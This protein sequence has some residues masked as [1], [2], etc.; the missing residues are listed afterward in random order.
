MTES[1]VK[2]TIQEDRLPLVIDSGTPKITIT[3]IEN[4]VTVIEENP[5]TITAGSNNSKVVVSSGWGSFGL[6]DL[7][8]NLT[9]KL[10]RI[11]MDPDLESDLNRLESLWVRVGNEL[12]LTYP[13]G[14]AIQEAGREY[15]D[16]SILDAVSNI[17]IST[18][19]KIDVAYSYINQ[20][21]S[22]IDQRIVSMEGDTEARFVINESRILQTESS[23]TSTVSR[24]DTIDGAGGSVELLQSSIDQTASS[25]DLEVSARLQ[26][27]DDLLTAQS[28]ISL[29]SDSIGLMVET[30]NTID[31]QVNTTS[32]V[33]GEDCI[34]FTIL[35]ESTGQN[36]YDI[37]VM[38][39]MLSN[40]WGVTIAEDVD[41]TTYATGFGLLL[42]PSWLSGESYTAGYTVVYSDVVYECKLG[43]V[44]AEENSPVSDAADTYWTELPDGVR[45]E[46]VISADALII[47][48]PT[49]SNVSLLENTETTPT[50]NS[51][52]VGEMAFEDTVELAKLGE[53]I[54]QGG[55]LKTE[56]IQTSS[57]VIGD[58]SGTL[59]YSS[60]SGTKPASDADNTQTAFGGTS[61]TTVR[62]NAASGATFTSANAGS[63]AYLSSVGDSHIT[64]IS[65]GKLSTGTIYANGTTS[66]W[67]LNTGHMY[68]SSSGF[69][70]FGSYGGSNYLWGNTA[71]VRTQA[72]SY[73]MGVTTSRIDFVTPASTIYYAG[74]SF[75]PLTSLSVSLGTG[76]SQWA[77][78]YTYGLLIKFNRVYDVIDDLDTLHSIKTN[79]DGVMDYRSLPDE[80]TSKDRVKNKLLS[81]LGEMVTEDD[82]DEML[83]DPDDVGSHIS[84][85][86]GN[87]VGLIEG[88]LR[89]LD[90]ENS[91]IQY[92][93]LNWLGDLENRLQL[94]ENI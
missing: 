59:D 14:V 70:Y 34:N 6:S 91:A 51:S 46:F 55:Y 48:T 66:Y 78:I 30:V 5:I 36:Q 44:S 75:Y 27:A 41:G 8:T 15:T 74:G 67:N 50:L 84:L 93:L 65:G 61:P 10:T 25:L 28:T 3:D 77:D 89:Q 11:H 18:D 73:N 57:I 63:L 83:D 42:Y 12:L 47:R 31:N 52:L 32:I 86:L 17:N 22:S 37:G 54:I 16:S 49:G 90:R 19:G 24:L 20:T 33:L 1:A 72:G 92:E 64:S 9:G 13:E 4:N 26:L 68:F 21:A 40:Q 53:T 81:E 7:L 2:V 39:S 38:Q 71:Q 87:F 94:L 56:L 85:D 76:S 29:L 88:G 69:M 58:L 82:I 80:F 43:H 60:I 79:D 35:Q 62:N 45:S 23:I